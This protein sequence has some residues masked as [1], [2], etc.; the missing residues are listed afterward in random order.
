[1]L[2]PKREKKKTVYKKSKPVAKKKRE[3]STEYTLRVP[4]K[5]KGE[6]VNKLKLT[7]GRYEY[8]NSHEDK[9]TAACSTS[10]VA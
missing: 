6:I 5:H 2:K 7:Y 1:M 3:V 4:L 8:T 9:A 10:N